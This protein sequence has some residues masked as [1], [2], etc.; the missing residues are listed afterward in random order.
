[1]AIISKAY[2]IAERAQSL[3]GALTPLSGM[4]CEQVPA[5]QYFIQDSP[6]RSN[7]NLLKAMILRKEI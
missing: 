1:V 7:A 3:D 2:S 6:D 5:Y 4:F